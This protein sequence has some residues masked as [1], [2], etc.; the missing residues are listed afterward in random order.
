M[1][2]KMIF[3]KLAAILWGPRLPERITGEHLEELQKRH[4]STHDLGDGVV[5]RAYDV[6]LDGIE[7]MNLL[8]KGEN[9][10]DYDQRRKSKRSK[11]SDYSAVGR[12]Q[13]I[14]G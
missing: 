13:E 7:R 4:D 10:A 2:P 8:D 5:W 6:R 9:H 1:T 12:G 14:R 11:D 3:K